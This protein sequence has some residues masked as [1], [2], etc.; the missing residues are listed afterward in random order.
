MKKVNPFFKILFVF[1]L[2]F[3]ALYIALESGYYDVKMGRKATITEEKLSMVEQAEE[4]VRSLGFGQFRVRIHGMLARIEILPDDMDKFMNV[5]IREKISKELK[6]LGFT[7]V[8][9]DLNGY[10]TG[11]MNE[12]LNNSRRI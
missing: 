5:S 9:L 7:Y 12:M 3:I 10:R 8:T 2:I 4:L 6:R 11:S 1:F